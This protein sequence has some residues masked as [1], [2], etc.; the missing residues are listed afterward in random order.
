MRRSAIVIAGRLPASDLAGYVIGQVV[1]AFIGCAVLALILTFKADGYDL[2]ASGLG[3]T[4]WNAATG[5]DVLGAFIAEMVGTLPLPRGDP[6]I[7]AEAERHAACRPCHRS[8]PS[9]PSF[10]AGARLRQLSLNPARS[11]APA[12]FVRGDALVQIW[13]YIVAPILGAAIAGF[14]FRTK[15]L[16]ED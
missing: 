3:Q 10:G 11:L 2:S 6:Q 5:F 13:L 4:T 15:V 9:D 7:Q 12:I 16:A 14:L 8:D 1:G